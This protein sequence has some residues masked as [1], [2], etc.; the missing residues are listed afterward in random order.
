MRRERD[1]TSALLEADDP[2]I[3]GGIFSLDDLS[4]EAGKGSSETRPTQ[5]RRP[6]HAP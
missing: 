4:V 5:P 1:T 6:A 2:G 3:A